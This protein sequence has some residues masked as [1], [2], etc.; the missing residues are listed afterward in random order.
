MIDTEFGVPTLFKLL[1]LVFTVSFSTFAIIISEFLPDSLI[2][3]KLSK[4]GYNLFGFF[5]QR[6]LIEMFY[7][8][9]ITNF[10]LNLGGQTTKVLDQGVIELLGP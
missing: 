8:K 4:F 9:Y 7:N 6:F 5:N 2:S 1:P 3:F 10:V